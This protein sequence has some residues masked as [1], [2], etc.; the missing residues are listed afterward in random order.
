MK[1]QIRCGNCGYEGPASEFSYV[2]LAGGRG[3]GTLWRCPACRELVIVDAPGAGRE[4]PPAPGALN[5]SEMGAS[6]HP[7]KTWR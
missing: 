7:V 6:A 1:R 3:P 2:A 5:P 4:N